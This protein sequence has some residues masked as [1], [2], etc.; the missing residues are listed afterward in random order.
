MTDRIGIFLGENPFEIAKRWLEEAALTESH[1]PN[2]MALATVDGKGLPDVRV[3][4]LK[5]IED[6]GFVFFTNYSS[7]KGQQIAGSGMAAFN[8]HWKS[9]ARQ[10][11]VRGEITKVSASSSEEYYQSRP[12]GSRIGAWASHQ[13]QVLESKN[14]LVQAVEDARTLH[15]ETPQRPDFW[16]G[17]KITPLEIEFWADGE[18]RLHDRFRWSRE[19]TGVSW[20]I[21]RLY[22]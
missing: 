22:P 21:E 9:L 10:I 13:S 11:R 14:S 7:Q 15:G 5:A 16:G 18:F 12:L 20:N 8:I 4:L 6:D 3:V 19:N 1:D 17:Y 2:A